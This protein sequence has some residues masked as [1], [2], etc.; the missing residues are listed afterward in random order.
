M[1]VASLLLKRPVGVSL[2]MVAL[3][4]TGVLAFGFLPV[5]SLP[6]VDYPTVMVT[7]SL[8]TELCN[9]E[10]DFLKAISNP[11]SC[12]RRFDALHPAR[13]GF[14]NPLAIVECRALA[15]RNV[16]AQMPQ[17]IAIKTVI[18]RFQK[19]SPGARHRAA[20]L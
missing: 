3:F 5:S 20:I 1:D 10:W 2:A 8:P 18:A 13:A 12:R 4:L 9:P 17:R 15:I 11:N 6:R 19:Q 7:A 14:G 16:I